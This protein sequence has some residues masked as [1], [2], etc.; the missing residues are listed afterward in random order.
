MTGFGFRIATVLIAT[1]SM[2]L[3]VAAEQRHLNALFIGNS[4]TGRHQLANVVKSM[5]EAGQKD[6]DFQVTTVIYG[7][8]RLA[9]HWR[10]GTQ[11][12]VNLHKLKKAEVVKTIQSLEETLNRDPDDNHAKSA[13]KRQKELL[14]E[15]DSSRKKWDVIVLQSYRDDL[16]GDGSLYMQFAPKFA[17]LAQQ[18]GARA[19]LYENNTDNAE[20]RSLNE[21]S[22]RRTHS[23]KSIVHRE[24][25]Q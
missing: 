20:C 4:Y 21:D 12:F 18:Q 8:R 3:G 7:G 24:A 17:D 22:R 2:A 16:D 14:N 9:D 1:A 23:R 11:N 10:L 5:A 13:I 19:I 25:C 6:L 15:L